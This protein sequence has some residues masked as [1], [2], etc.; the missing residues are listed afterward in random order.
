MFNRIGKYLGMK[1]FSS[2]SFEWKEKCFVLS[3]RLDWGVWA[4]CQ[5][6][7]DV[8]RCGMVGP[9]GDGVWQEEKELTD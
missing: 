3:E 9:F 2:R 7:G 4:F 5:T 6:G 1:F 8:R